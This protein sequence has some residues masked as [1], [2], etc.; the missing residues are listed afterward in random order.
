MELF[1]LTIDDF[2]LLLLVGVFN[3]AQMNDAIL[4][5][6]R[7]EDASLGWTA[8]CRLRRCWNE[9]IAESTTMIAKSCSVLQISLLMSLFSPKWVVFGK[10]HLLLHLIC[11]FSVQITHRLQFAARP[12]SKDYSIQWF[13]LRVVRFCCVQRVAP[14]VA[15]IFGL[16]PSVAG[17]WCHFSL[18]RD[19]PSNALHRV[20]L[21]VS[22]R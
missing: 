7:Y 2:D 16:W 4:K 10:K 6:R 5:F 17:L 13:P 22:S 9:M 15:R 1:G 14:S 8:P 18:F 21:V 19:S 3:R 20:F 12:I 11:H